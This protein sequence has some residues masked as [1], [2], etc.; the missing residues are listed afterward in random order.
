MDTIHI[1]HVGPFSKSTR[2]NS[3]LLVIVDA[4]SKFVVAKPSRSLRS[5]E[6]IDHLKEVFGTFGVPRRIVSDRGLAFTSKQFKQFMCDKG[7]IHVLTAIATPRANGQV[8]RMN[9][10][11]LDGLSTSIVD[12]NRWDDCLHD[13]IYGINHTVNASTGFPPSEL[14]FLR[15]Q[16]SDRETLP[17]EGDQDEL[18]RVGRGGSSL[19]GPESIAER[20]G[21]GHDGSATST[22]GDG[23]SRVEPEPVSA[24]AGVGEASEWTVVRGPNA[25]S[26]GEERDRFP[27]TPGSLVNLDLASS[28]LPDRSGSSQRRMRAPE[29]GGSSNVSSENE[30]GRDVWQSRRDQM[31]SRRNRAG[32]NIV[33]AA[34][35]NERNF[36]RRRKLSIG[37][38]VNDLVLWRDAS[39]YKKV[40]RDVNNKL[41]NKFDGP[42]RVG[43]TL[44]HDRYVIESV[45]G[46]RGYKRFSAIVA[47][48]A[49]RPYSSCFAESDDSDERAEEEEN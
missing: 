32:H 12:E 33:R 16:I 18:I 14:M 36:N 3:Y 17:R 27:G 29:G 40:G 9:R 20:S 21:L 10:T 22:S 35:R 1:D 44:P 5:G 19:T 4:F 13:V 37:Y 26:S 48:D 42:F 7:I 11:I 43:K 41:S 49:L 24:V 6:V 47:A 15:D 45:K 30:R 38:S 46:I 2:G 25:R 31:R 23:I 39:T 34:K 28:T 8:E